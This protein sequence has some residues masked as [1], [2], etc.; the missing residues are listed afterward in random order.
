MHRLGWLLAILLSL[1]LV[2][3][4]QDTLRTDSF[5]RIESENDV[6]QLRKKDITDRYYS[7]GLRLTMQSNYWS[8]WPTRRLLLTLPVR[9]NHAYDRLYQV[10]IGQETYTPR[11]IVRPSPEVQN[12][13]YDRPYAGYLYTSF[14]VVSTD[15]TSGRKL[16]SNLVL[17]VIGPISAAAEGQKALHRLIHDIQ[18]VG[19]NRQ[20]RDD[21]AVSY[22]VRYEQRLAGQP[23]RHLELIGLLDGNIG[24]LTNYAGTGLTL[25]FG[26]F[27]DYFQRANGLYDSRLAR[28]RNG[29][30]GGQRPFQFYTFVQPMFRAV[31]DNSLLTGGWLNGNKEPYALPFAEL[32]HGYTQLEYG[33]VVAYRGFLFSFTTV[34]RSREYHTGERQQWGRITTHWRW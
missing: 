13:H 30:T 26:R 3:W 29:V 27:N 33:G 24:T 22:S 23:L 16:T 10:E 8:R 34:V 19:W 14:G 11:T 21:I 6:Y 25:R 5:F 18:P 32:L 12:G 17:G 1:P 15:A 20:I 9:A 2:A 4:S 31:L 7:N 28:R